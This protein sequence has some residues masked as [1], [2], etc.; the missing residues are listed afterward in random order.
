MIT[1]SGVKCGNFLAS[2]AVTDRMSKTFTAARVQ[3]IATEAAAAYRAAADQIEAQARVADPD[4][5]MWEIHRVILG[6]P[7][8]ALH[9]LA[10]D[11]IYPA[12][13]DA[14]E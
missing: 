9:E 2:F 14:A 4:E 13:R 10:Q 12:L 3:G 11:V 1:F 6:E 5:A 8:G 7:L